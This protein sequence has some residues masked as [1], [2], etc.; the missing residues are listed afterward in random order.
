MFDIIYCTTFS[1]SS[2][3]TCH[4]AELY[5]S[6]GN[7]P[8]RRSSLT[9]AQPLTIRAP[10]EQTKNISIVCIYLLPL[11]LWRVLNT[12]DQ[13]ITSRGCLEVK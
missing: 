5:I 4:D 10:S 3:S 6:S 13:A 12:N 1:T 2:T 8:P 7:H 11:D 9:Y